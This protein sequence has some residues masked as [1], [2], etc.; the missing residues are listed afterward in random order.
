MYG[1]S[2]YLGAPEQPE[3]KEDKVLSKIEFRI[4]RRPS[5]LKTADDF[6]GLNWDKKMEYDKSSVR[7]K[8]EHAFLNSQKN[9]WAMRKQLTMESKRT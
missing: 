7:C 5:S 9:K 6:K 4:N 3:I 8:V 2:G 1:V